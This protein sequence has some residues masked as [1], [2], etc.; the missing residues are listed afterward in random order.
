MKRDIENTEK[1]KISKIES[2]LTQYGT[3]LKRIAYLYLKDHALT[4]DIIQEVFISCY[5]HIEQ[6]REESSY[7][8]WLI[9]ITVNKC[10]DTLKRW[11]FRNIVY[12]EKMDLNIAEA[13]TPE[14]QTIS[15]IE[16]VLLAKEILALPVKFREVIIL[17]Y[18]Q[19]LSIEEISNILDLKTNTIKTRLHR[20]R[21][22]LREAL[23]RGGN[24]WKRN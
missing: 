15:K 14:I 7:K 21:I 20:A 22:R 2:L 16:D 23:E 19:D 5:N 9:K 24:E 6:F 13:E 8:T 11:S 10:K 12:K 4:E 18:Y 3:E 17:Y 1:G